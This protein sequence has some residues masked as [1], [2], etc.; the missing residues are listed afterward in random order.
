MAA[1]P[2]LPADERATI[3]SCLREADFLAHELAQIDREIAR[4]AVG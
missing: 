4:C 2:Q 3:L 1:G